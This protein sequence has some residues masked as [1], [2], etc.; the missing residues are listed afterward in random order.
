MLLQNSIVA[1][2]G[3]HGMQ[4]VALRIDSD[5]A[6]FYKVKILGAQD[7]LLDNTGTHYFYKSHIR[8]SVDFIF[9]SAKSLYQVR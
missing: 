8:G 6:V 5:R 1:V 9:G 2:P 3:G 4:A 7:T